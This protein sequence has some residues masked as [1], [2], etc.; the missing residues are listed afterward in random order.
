MLAKSLVILEGCRSFVLLRRLFLPL[1]FRPLG[2]CVG[3]IGIALAY[4]GAAHD[5]PEF[6]VVCY[7]LI[8]GGVV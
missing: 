8:V 4:L 6:P 5:Q 2:L 3:P 7:G 1:A